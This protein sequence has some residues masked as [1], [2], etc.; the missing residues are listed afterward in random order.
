MASVVQYSTGHEESLCNS[1]HKYS[2]IAD[3]GTKEAIG[4]TVSCAN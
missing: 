4:Y 2:V 3:T 1:L